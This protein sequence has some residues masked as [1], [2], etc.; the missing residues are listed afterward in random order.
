MKTCL[1]GHTG[2]VGANILKQRQFDRCFNSK[3]IEQIVGES[4]SELVCAG[5]SGT[6]WIA[7]KHPAEDK[8]RIEQLLDKMAKVKAQSVIL[9]STIDVY[10]NP[11]SKFDEDHDPKEL[12]H[13]PY[14]VH[15]RA[16][17]K[18]FTELFENLLIVRL[19]GLFG[20]GLKKNPIY[21]LMHGHHLESMQAESVYQWYYLKHL[22]NDIELFQKQGLKL[23]N[24]FTEPVKTR[25]IID[26]FFSDR[27]EVGGN[28][29]V[30][31]RG[32]RGQAQVTLPVRYDLRTKYADVFSGTK[33]YVRSKNQV[34]EDFAEFFAN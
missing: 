13:Y 29:S 4:Y 22:V 30:Y 34:L 5:V 27:Y 15:R 20:E 16:V 14:G 26:R 6:K 24:L 10:Q 2:F 1:I 19:P 23:V 8:N 17:E 12:P 7:N 31:P 11:I 32:T 33:G 9:I 3:N 28:G 21:D 18:R 25:E